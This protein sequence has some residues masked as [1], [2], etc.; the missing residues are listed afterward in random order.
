M[1]CENPEYMIS[2]LLQNEKYENEY[3]L[4]PNVRLCKLIFDSDSAAI[5]ME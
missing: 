4:K 3:E 2:T 1:K 5:R